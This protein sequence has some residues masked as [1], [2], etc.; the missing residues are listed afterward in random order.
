MENQPKVQLTAPEITNLWQQF[1]LESLDVCLK[2]YVLAH[3]EDADIRSVFKY[4]LSLSENHI[5]KVKHFFNQE[6]YPLPIGFTDKDVHLNAPRLFSDVFWLK[7]IQIM[8]ANGMPNYSL[9]ISTS[10]RSDIR[11]YFSQCNTEATELY[12]KSMDVL[13]SKGLFIRPTHFPV[14]DRQE[15]IKNNSLLSNLIG[16]RKPLNGFEISHI[17]FNLQKTNM[18]ATL[19]LGFS[20]VTQSKKI[21]EIITRILDTAVKHSDLFQSILKEDHIDL[22]RTWENEVTNSKTPPFSDKLMMS[23]AALALST[24]IFYY[25]TAL[26]NTMRKDLVGHY[27]GIIA[28]DL[29]VAEDAQNIM[30]DNGWLEQPPQSIDHEALIKL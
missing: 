24:A 12:N 1:I 27:M 5:E 18:A 14:P 22:P 17:Y 23:H 7:Y 16:H 15:F 13:L 4:A 10:V 6:K 19:L 21:H 11:D 29:I 9:A 25:G 26:S 2:K 28:K 30:V 8:S 20:Q 3:I